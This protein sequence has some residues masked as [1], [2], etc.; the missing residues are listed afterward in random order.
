MITLL[1]MIFSYHI[2]HFNTVERC[3]LNDSI[4]CAFSFAIMC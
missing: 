3:L 1:N 2:I 4:I